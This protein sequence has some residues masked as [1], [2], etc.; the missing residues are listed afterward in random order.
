MTILSLADRKLSALLGVALIAVISGGSGADSLLAWRSASWG[1][2]QPPWPGGR[3]RGPAAPSA[4][5]RS[6]GDRLGSGLAATW[7]EKRWRGK[8]ARSPRRPGAPPPLRAGPWRS[9]ARAALS[10]AARARRTGERGATVA[11]LAAP[12]RR[13]RRPRP[14]AGSRCQKPLDFGSARLWRL[15]A[16]WRERRPE[17]AG[18]GLAEAG[19][20]GQRLLLPL[21][22]PCA[23][24]WSQLLRPCCLPRCCSSSRSARAKRCWRATLVLTHA[25]YFQ[26]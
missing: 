11:L 7:P 17:A 23:Q 12:G 22:A 24:S 2:K 25:H 13:G 16:P 14:G 10:L 3:R 21:P 19:L 4:A 9:S 15:L 1:G 6:A 8:A 20:L 26:L 18:P 5:E